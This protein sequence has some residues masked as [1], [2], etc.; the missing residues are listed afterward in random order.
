[1]NAY[2]QEVLC[3]A[4]VILCVM[5]AVYDLCIL[6]VLGREVTKRESDSA[7][8]SEFLCAING[9]VM[10]EPLRSRTS[11]RYSLILLVV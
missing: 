3:K 1:M 11:G 10:K 8:P 4:S 7:I 2:A 6:S 5:F 9:H